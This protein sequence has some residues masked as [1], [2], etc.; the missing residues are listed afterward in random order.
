M[1]KLPLAAT[2]RLHK[3]LK[4]LTASA[5]T[6]AI[7]RL[8]LLSFPQEPDP[9]CLRSIDLIWPWW[10]LHTHVLC[11]VSPRYSVSRMQLCSASLAMM[12]K[13]PWSVA[14]QSVA[15]PTRPHPW[16]RGCMI[17]RCVNSVTEASHAFAVNTAPASHQPFSPVFFPTLAFPKALLKC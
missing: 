6:L 16:R 2:L 8:P 14:C 11:R 4:K 17:Q 13:L 10:P 15:V 1:V 9:R 3:I 7:L 5:Q 12:G